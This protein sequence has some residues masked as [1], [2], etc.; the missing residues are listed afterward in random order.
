M[1][2][3]EARKHAELINNSEDALRI[4]IRFS[5]VLRANKKY[6]EAES[7]LSSLGKSIDFSSPNRVHGHFHLAQAKVYFGLCEEAKETTYRFFSAMDNYLELSKKHAKL[8]LDIAQLL[9]AEQDEIDAHQFLIA[10][11]NP[12]IKLVNHLGFYSPPLAA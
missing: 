5:N 10:L 4:A 8:A 3:E 11:M 12:G 7:I 1:G 9:K 6:G 2:C